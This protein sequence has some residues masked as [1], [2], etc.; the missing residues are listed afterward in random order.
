MEVNILTEETFKNSVRAWC[1]NRLHTTAP[2]HLLDSDGRA[3]ERFVFDSFFLEE[4]RRMVRSK[5][6]AKPQS[7]LNNMIAVKRVIRRGGVQP[8]DTPSTNT[9]LKGLLRQYAELYGAEVLCP[10]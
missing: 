5:A 8:I 3:R 2:H 9:I 6:T 1:V 10:K 4:Y 7:A